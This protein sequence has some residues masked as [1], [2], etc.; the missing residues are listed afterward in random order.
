MAH[1]MS[2]LLDEGGSRLLRPQLPLPILPAKLSLPLLP[3]RLRNSKPFVTEQT[4]QSV[5]PSPSPTSP[6]STRDSVDFS[7]PSACRSRRFHRQ[8]PLIP[9]SASWA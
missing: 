3:A 5:S 1:G 9:T 6:S 2:D 4:T 7:Q 8:T